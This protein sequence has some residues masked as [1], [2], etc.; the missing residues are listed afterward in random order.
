MFKRVNR[1]SKRFRPVRGWVTVGLT[2]AVV[3]A[4]ACRREAPLLPST[5][6]D[7]QWIWSAADLARW[8]TAHATRPTLRPGLWVST[9]WWEGGADGGV[10]QRLALSPRPLAGA[11]LAVVV[12][13]DDRMHAAWLAASDSAIALQL[14]HALRELLRLV[15]ATGTDVRE[16]QLDYDCPVRRLAR[17]AA[18]VRRLRAGAL[19]GREVWI[20]SLVAHVAQ[21]DYGTYFRGVVSGHIVQVFDLFASGGGGEPSPAAAA[22]LA[23]HLDRAGLP[24]RLGVGAF[25]RV[26]RSGDGGTRLTHHRAWFALAPGLARSPW[27]RGLWV[28]PGGQPWTSLVASPDSAKR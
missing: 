13:V 23:A 24:F 3:G 1:R 25:E 26:L 20:T 2:T 18:V 22:R 8:Q 15:A 16:V 28:F 5:R 14:D 10:R 19:A 9:V 12:R 11:P 27:Y 4:G 6:A 7:G 21:R 17:W